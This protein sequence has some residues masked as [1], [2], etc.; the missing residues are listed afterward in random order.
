ML[1]KLYNKITEKQLVSVALY[2]TT[3]IIGCMLYVYKYN[4]QG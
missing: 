1:V 3:V 2:F 4:Y